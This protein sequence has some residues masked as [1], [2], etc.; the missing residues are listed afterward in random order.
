MAGEDTHIK[1]IHQQ[2]DV[3]AGEDMHVK[4]IHQQ[5]DVMAGEDMHIVMEVGHTMMK[6][7]SEC[8]IQWYMRILW[9]ELKC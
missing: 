9:L 2:V 4:I 7:C 8:K 3:M 6:G 1:I 5:V